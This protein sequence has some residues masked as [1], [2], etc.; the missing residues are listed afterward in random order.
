MTDQTYRCPECGYQYDEACGDLHEGYP[1]GTRW[2]DLPSNFCCPSCAVRD[3]SD[4]EL[5]SATA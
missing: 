1:P 3:K 2:A 5:L 4:F